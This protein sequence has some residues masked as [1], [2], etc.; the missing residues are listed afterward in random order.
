VAS[1]LLCFAL[2]SDCGEAKC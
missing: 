1:V 2:D